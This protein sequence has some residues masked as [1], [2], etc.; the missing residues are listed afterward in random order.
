MFEKRSASCI[1]DFYLVMRNYKKTKKLQDQ[2][3]KPGSLFKNEGCVYTIFS[4]KKKENGSK[5]IKN[6]VQTA[7]K[8][9]V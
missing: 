8:K 7:D 4:D 3:D 2:Y 5:N 6:I 9:N 1:Y